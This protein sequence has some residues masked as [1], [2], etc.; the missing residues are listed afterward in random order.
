MK[1][2]KF[3]RV[4]AQQQEIDNLKVENANLT[5]ENEVL[6]SEK[7]N[8]M[9][10]LEEGAE[11]IKSL[12]G[13]YDPFWFCSFGGCEGVC[14]EC[15]DLC[16]K[17]IF[18]QERKETVKEILLPLRRFLIER[19]NYFG[20]LAKQNEAVSPDNRLFDLGEQDM[21]NCTLDRIK[22]VLEKYGVE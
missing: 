12:S 2:K 22:E 17:S 5:V 18:V 20:K 6:Q 11:E 15:K 10:T 21:A 19:F 16:E 3:E 9:R 14:K 8:L 13:N 1:I 7:D 4:K